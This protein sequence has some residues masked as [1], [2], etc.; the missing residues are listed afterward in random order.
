MNNKIIRKLK[1]NEPLTEEEIIEIGYFYINTRKIEKQITKITRGN[2]PSYDIVDKSITINNSNQSFWYLESLKRYANGKRI[3]PFIEKPSKLNEDISNFLF[4]DSLFHEIRH[5]EQKEILTNKSNFSKYNLLF[6]KHLL[7]STKEMTDLKNL[8]YH[9]YLYYEY[10]ADLNAI[11]DVNEF[12]KNYLNN[13]KITEYNKYASY[14]ILRYYLSP[15]AKEISCP[16]DNNNQIN[17]KN[18]QKLYDNSFYDN[19]IQLKPYNQSFKE[20]YDYL[21]TRTI[22]EPT[23][24]LEK[25]LTG[26]KLN[27]EHLNKLSEIYK[28]NI[29]TKD[30]IKTI[31]L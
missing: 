12:N 15:G 8:L 3:K 18:Y 19:I 20:L 1:N 2:E 24:T 13:E 16:I 17:K 22:E 4:L 27:I 10:D 25:L 26:S 29:K 5:G 14:I 6:L 11:K 9:D 21:N 7:I 31:T 28:G 30:I 23:T